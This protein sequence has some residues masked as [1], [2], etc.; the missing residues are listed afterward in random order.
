M[1]AIHDRKEYEYKRIAKTYVTETLS[2]IPIQAI[3]AHKYLNTSI[4]QLKPQDEQETTY[5]GRQ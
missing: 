2:L 4:D 5:K 1:Q 3:S